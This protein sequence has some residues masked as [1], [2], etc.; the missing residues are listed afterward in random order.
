M[1]RVRILVLAALAAASSPAGAP[2]QTAGCTASPL[3]NPQGQVIHCAD[4][5][6]INAESGAEYRL[7]DRDRDRRPE[8]VELTGKALLVDLPPTGRRGGFQILTPHAIASVRGTAWA[9]DVTEART[10]VF[11]ERGVVRVSRPRAGAVTLR[12]G[13]GVD[14]EA[15]TRSLHVKRWSPERAAAL[16][17]RLRP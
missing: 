7:L 8:A 14:V 17:A 13:D 12:A 5:L 10:S 1:R 3:P 15:G 6:T 16:L 2:A 9:V 11:V 4:G